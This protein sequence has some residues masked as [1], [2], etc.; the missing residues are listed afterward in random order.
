[1]H[2]L[3][4]STV[5]SEH[6]LPSSSLP[7]HPCFHKLLMK[8]KQLQAEAHQGEKENPTELNKLR[9]GYAVTLLNCAPTAGAAEDLS[10]SPSRV[11]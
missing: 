2:Q 6:S 9:V 5:V 4:T 8:G 1:M 7:R 11:P 3:G 10:S